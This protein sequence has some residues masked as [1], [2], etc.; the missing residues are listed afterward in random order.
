MDNI[1]NGHFGD[2]RVIGDGVS[3][4]RF[5]VRSGIRIYYFQREQEVIVLLAGGNKDSQKKDIETA[6]K[7]VRQIR[8]EN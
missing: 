3:E 1:S 5:H 2:Y 4:L 7:L 8:E 6:K